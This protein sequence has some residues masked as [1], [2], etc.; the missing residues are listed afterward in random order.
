MLLGGSPPRG[1]P[2][3]SFEKSEVRVLRQF[4]EN[5]EF[6]QNVRIVFEIFLFRVQGI[7]GSPIFFLA[8]DVLLFS[9][10]P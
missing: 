4:L 3:Q 9:L 10:I 5:G 6:R 1:G 7:K 8:P 2:H